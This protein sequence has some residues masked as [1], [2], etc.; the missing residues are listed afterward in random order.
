MNLASRIRRARKVLGMS[1]AD[2]A[3]KM[4]VHRSCVGHWEGVHNANP[5]PDR[6]AELS[7][8]LVVSYEWLATGRGEMKLGHDPA[9]DIPAAFGK[10]VD[11]P[12]LLRVVDAWGRMSLRS[13]NALLEIAEELAQVRKPRTVKHNDAIQLESGVF[14]SGTGNRVAPSKIR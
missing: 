14:D 3:R 6:L 4:N 12:E 5:G 1:Q 11:E 8:V 10:L 7:I 9:N 13:R 2:L